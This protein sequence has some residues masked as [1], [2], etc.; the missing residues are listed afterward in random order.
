MD[1][2]RGRPL[3]IDTSA[4]SAADGVPAFLS[5]PPDTAVYY[6]FP[7]LDDVEVDGL[8]L[9]M[10]TDETTYVSAIETA[11]VIHTSEVSGAS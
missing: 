1:K 11:E 5:R 8:R 6:G 4:E 3:R 10:I 7:V 9:G 2:P